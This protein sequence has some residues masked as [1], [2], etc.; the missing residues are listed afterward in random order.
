MLKARDSADAGRSP[1]KPSGRRSRFRFDGDGLSCFGIEDCHR[2]AARRRWSS[3]HRNRRLVARPCCIPEVV[4]FALSLDCSLLQASDRV[5]KRRFRWCRVVVQNPPEMVSDTLGWAHI[6][7]RHVDLPDISSLVPPG[8][9]PQ[10]SPGC[11]PEHGDQACNRSQV[12][13]STRG[14]NAQNAWWR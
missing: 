12:W 14:R 13:E 7:A 11:V 3:V 5:G 6:L 1:P 2:A 10:A 9:S 4:R 8:K